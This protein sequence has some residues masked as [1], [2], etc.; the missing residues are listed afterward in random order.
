[1]VLATQGFGSCDS[2][3]VVSQGFGDEPCGGPV[4]PTPAA[5]RVPQRT[6]TGGG[7][8]E[9]PELVDYVSKII[10]EEPA[11]LDLQPIF[12]GDHIDFRPTI[13]GKPKKKGIIDLDPLFLQDLIKQG[14]ELDKRLTRKLRLLEEKERGL[15]EMEKR[16]MAEIG[17]ERKALQEQ[18]ALS[19]KDKESALKAK[20]MFHGGVTVPLSKVRPADAVYVWED[21]KKFS[22]FDEVIVPVG[23]GF[24]LGASITAAA[25]L[26][27]KL[28]EGLTEKKK[29]K[30]PQMAADKKDESD[31]DG[32]IVPDGS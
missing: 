28:W 21:E 8:Y 7:V 5:H 20:S 3:V 2:G 24:G 27:N 23:I 14:Q 26:A 1:M 19:M 11:V 12:D 31:D 30:S 22:L 17:M 4:P 6:V 18:S 25:L 16:I 9:V 29:R 10:E 15:S 13:K 32:L